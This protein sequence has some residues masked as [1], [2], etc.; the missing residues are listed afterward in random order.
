MIYLDNNATTQPTPAV[1]QAI[2]VA[3]T[4]LWANPSSVHRPGQE[5]RHALELA[6]KELATLLGVPSR[7]IVLTSSGT[8]SINLAIRGVLESNRGG[9]LPAPTDPHPLPTIVTTRLEHTAVRDLVLHLER[10]G[11]VEIRWL[12]LDARGIADPAALDALLDDRTALVS[13][14]W[15]NNETGVIQPV[16]R[17]AEICR[18]R[19]VPFH[20]DAVQW[21]GKMPLPEALPCDLLTFSAH[22]FHGP[23]GVGGLWVRRGVGLVPQT[24]GTQETDRRGGTESVA[25]IVGAGVA[26]R[27]AAAWLA[28]PTARAKTAALRDR[29]ETEIIRRTPTTPGAV[30]NSRDCPRLW[31]TTSIAF[32]ALEAEAMLMLLSERGLAAS[33]GAACSS[34]S[35]DPSPVLL[36]MGIPEPL[37]HGS[38]RFSL[39]RNTTDAEINDAIEIVVAAAT[40]LGRSSASTR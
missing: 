2:H 24:I 31:N 23:K 28:D 16:E 37:A 40:Q 9:T 7:E 14:Q 1:A 38:I 5:A 30:I 32:P 22:K 10:Q 4:T 20:C 15:A 8:E 19:G 35:L 39:T 33:A 3:T 18:A 12:P 25:A 34:G 26:A 29:F 6:R 27:E 17:L 11:Q 13:V 36:A 21:V